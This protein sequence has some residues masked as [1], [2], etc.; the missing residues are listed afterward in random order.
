VKDGTAK[1]RGAGRR[2]DPI[3]YFAFIRESNR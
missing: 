1:A 2:Q 3:F